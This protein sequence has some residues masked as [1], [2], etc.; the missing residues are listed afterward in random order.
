NQNIQHLF[1]YCIEKVIEKI[2]VPEP[3]AGNLVLSDTADKAETTCF[4]CSIS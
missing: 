2:D 3:S 4:K 1:D